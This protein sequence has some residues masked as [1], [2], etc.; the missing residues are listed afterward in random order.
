[1]VVSAGSKQSTESRAAGATRRLLGRGEREKS[2][3]ELLVELRELLVGYAR[4]ELVDPLQ[5]LKRF[6]GLWLAGGALAGVGLFLLALGVLRAVE[7]ET[8][9]H[10]TGHW[11]WLPYLVTLIVAAIILAVVLSLV[12]RLRTPKGDAR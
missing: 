7:T 8:R 6:V 2:F 1:M 4:Q 3:P 9:P 5:A 12:R 10:F 11:S